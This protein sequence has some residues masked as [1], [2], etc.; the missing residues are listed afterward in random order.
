VPVGIDDDLFNF[1]CYALTCG[2]L[3]R[4]ENVMLY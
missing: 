1:A 4:E 2:T 3:N